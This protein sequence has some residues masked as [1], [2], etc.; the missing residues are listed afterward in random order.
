MMKFS[1]ILESISTLELIPE[2]FNEDDWYIMN[3]KTKKI[4]KHL[5]KIEVSYG[6]DPSSNSRIKAELK[7]PD[8]VA[9]KGMKAKHFASINENADHESLLRI[10]QKGH[11]RALRKGNAT[12]AKHY[13]SRMAFHTKYLAK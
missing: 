1:H 4:V 7:N 2:S 9:M 5:G 11:L 8:Y 10:A 3:K 12:L 6:S 13:A